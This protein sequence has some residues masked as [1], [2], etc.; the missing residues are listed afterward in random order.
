MSFKENFPVFA[1]HEGEWV[2]EYI[3]TDVAGNIVDR[4]GSHIL[5]KIDDVGESPYQQTN[6]YRWPSGKFEQ[7]SFAGSVREGKVYYETG[8]I[9]GYAWEV[10]ELTIILRFSYKNDPSN[11]V[12]E[13]VQICPDGQ[14]RARYWNWYVNGKLSKR[15]LI[16]EHRLR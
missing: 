4:Y 11:Y 6:T 7:Y 3:E 9:I 5:F 1:K 13:L 16:E 2:G 15:T 12:Y 10:D 14:S 8:R